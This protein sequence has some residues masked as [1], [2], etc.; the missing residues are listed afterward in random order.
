M[1]SDSRQVSDKR[2]NAVW[3]TRKESLNMENMLLRSCAAMG[4]GVIDSTIE[5]NRRGMKRF[6][7]RQYWNDMIFDIIVV[8]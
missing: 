7:K 6:F 1:L 5:Q 4:H 3:E 2:W 8:C